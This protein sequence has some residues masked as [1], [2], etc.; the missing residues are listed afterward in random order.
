M[1]PVFYEQIDSPSA[2]TA[3]SLEGGRDAFTRKLTD[4]QLQV[5]DELLAATSDIPPQEVTRE[6]FSHPEL[7]DWLTD[8]FNEIQ[9]GQGVVVISGLSK[10]KYSPEMMERIYWGF[11]THWGIAAVQTVLGDKLGRVTF[12]PVGPENPSGRAYRS[13][14]ELYLHTDN[15][16]MVGLMCLEKAASGGFTRLASSIAIHNEI[17]RKR[18]ELLEPLYEGFYYAS[19]EAAK[20]AKPVTDYKIPVYCNV[21]GV[22]SCRYTR[23]FIYRAGRELDGL[24][25]DLEQ[26][27]EYM[28]AIGDREDVQ[29][30][31]TLEPGEMLIINNYT[32]LHSRTSFEDGP[33]QKRSLLRLWLD[34][35]GGRPVIEP[36]M[37]S[38]R[39]YKAKSTA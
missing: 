15:Y 14:E 24:P 39:E 26:A 2:W 28:N 31:F 25:E 33:D 3:S 10:E 8:I 7:D 1:T 9:H 17:A 35:P 29:V 37:S 4:R 5:I 22:V 18:P 12:T 38:A 20:S 6:Q 32:T 30:E 19:R 23:E 21:D 11:G 16:E 13:N 27:L 36:F 34:V